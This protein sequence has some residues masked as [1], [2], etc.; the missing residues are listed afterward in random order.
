MEEKSPKVFFPSRPKIIQTEI[1]KVY[2]EGPVKRN[3]CSEDG[4]RPVPKKYS[5]KNS[6]NSGI[7]NESLE[8][9][10]F[11]NVKKRAYTES[12]NEQRRGVISN[13]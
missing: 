8:L 6:N 5:Y 13:S 3:I 11:Y 12:V 1:M 9:L 2:Q 4:A 10:T 7:R